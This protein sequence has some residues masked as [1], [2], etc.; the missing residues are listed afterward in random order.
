MDERKMLGEPTVNELVANNLARGI[1]V[2]GKI[3]EGVLHR[4]DYFPFFR[5]F[6]NSSKG[7]QL[8]TL[9]FS[10]QARLA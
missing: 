5:Y 9:P 7:R 1:V 3:R 4:H 10:T 6:S 8:I 2:F